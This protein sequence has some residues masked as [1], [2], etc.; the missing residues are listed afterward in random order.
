MDA[1]LFRTD[2]AGTELI[3]ETG[4]LAR[5]AN[6]AVTARMGDTVVLATA[7]M[8]GS[9][10]EG[11]DFFPLMV[12][13]EER[14]YAAGAIKGN[15]Y[16]KREGRP[17]NDAILTGRL[18]D[19]G[20][21][22]LFPQNLRNEVQIIITPLSLD[23]VNRPD[24]L[25][26]V[27]ACAALHCSDIPFD[28]PVA[29]VRIGKV[30]GEMIV[31]PSF[32]HLNDSE[33]EFLVTGSGERIMMVDASANNLPDE[34]M[35]KAFE[36]AMQQLGPMTKFI[37]DMRSKVGIP[38]KELSEL[39]TRGDFTEDDQKIMEEMKK[40]I[41]PQL[42]RYLFNVPRGSKGERKKILKDLKD[43]VIEQIT[44]K[45]VSEGKTE[46]EAEAYLDKIMGIFF[47]DFIEEQV[48]KAILDEDKRVDGRTLDQIRPLEAEIALLPRT[49][50]SGLFLRGETQVLSVVTL[51]APGDEM[52]IETMEINTEKKYFH[53]YNFPP[54]SVGETKMLR[55]AS[56]RDIGHGALAEKALV[57]MLPVEEI[58]FPY[59]IRVTSEVMGSNGSS[60]MAATCGSTLALMDAGVPI[61][62][63]VAGIAI[64]LASDGDKWKIVTDIQDL[65]DGKG[66]MDFKITGTKD[67]VTAIQMDT[68]TR[69]ITKEIIGEAMKYGRKALNEIITVLEKAI[70]EPRPELSPYAPRIISFMI[71]PEQ[72]GA[73][74]GPGGKI[75]RALTEEY[76]VQIDIEDDGTVHITSTESEAA[77]KAEAR[78]KEITRVIEM[79]DVFEEAEV[80]RIMNF[81]AFCKLTEGNDGLLHV[82]EIAWERVENVED[83]LKLGDKVKV[84]VIKIEGGKVNI[85]MKALLPK[86]E[87]WVD[88]PPRRDDRRGGGGGRRDD[89]RGGGR[90]DDRRGGGGGG[91]RR[92][93][94]RGGGGGGG[95]PRE[96]RY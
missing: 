69:G 17:P 85:S 7:S 80:V 90:R 33:L 47:M 20:L 66:G 5:Q 91:G 67:T 4:K 24:I 42:D 39:T 31:N 88:R 40:I 26:L 57:P 77:A 14:Y 75:I 89:R 9:G 83:R 59:T 36:L 48:T 49:H 55:G 79:G 68:K 92:D 23:G 2:F 60:S 38:K 54:Y 62:K 94:R 95:R 10:R 1:K 50:G 28:G 13:Y 58:E 41:L 63:H 25:G 87:G 11:M 61:T 71:D 93:D 37:E 96:K 34:E 12:D 72:I 52:L 73:V 78:I 27:A 19:R 81:G 35:V 65:E 70:P 3:I 16:Q 64:G 86:P 29:G 82:S 15:R 56:R 76:G 53:H 46:E 21:R 18:I 6:F 51:G 44:K 22:P 84:K 74:I 32:E 30:D 43:M 45:L 8:S